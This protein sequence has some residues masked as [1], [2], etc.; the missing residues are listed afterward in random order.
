MPL[1]LVVN[2]GV[3]RLLESVMASV[4]NYVCAGLEAPRT[5]V[6]VA[7]WTVSQPSAGHSVAIPTHLRMN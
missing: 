6:Q 3:P 7:A 4:W 5:L 1:V 2:H